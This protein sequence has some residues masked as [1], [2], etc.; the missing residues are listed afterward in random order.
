M[1][2]LTREYVIPLRRSWLIVPEYR[3]A[4]RAAKAIKQFI[5]KHMKVPER[6]VEKVKLDMYLNNEIWFRGVRNPPSKI[7][8]R[9]TKEGDI[10]KVELAE[11]PEHVKFLKLKHEKM[12]KVAEKKPEKAEEKKEAEVGVEESTKKEKSEE[13]KAE[14]KKAEQEKEKSGEEEQMKEAKHEKL[15]DKHITKVKGTEIHRKALNRH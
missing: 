4:G 14:E 9:A 15:A 8:V 3:R 1:I 7:K 12:F 10:V 13:K 5:A 6:D 2:E 11:I